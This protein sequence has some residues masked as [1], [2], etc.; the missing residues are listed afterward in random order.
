M[1]FYSVCFIQW[2]SKLLAPQSGAHRR[3]AVNRDFQS[4]PTHNLWA[5]KPVYVYRS[6]LLPKSVVSL[7]RPLARPTSVC[8]FAYFSLFVYL[9]LFAYFCPFHIFAYWLI[10]LVEILISHFS[11]LPQGKPHWP[12][13]GATF[14][15]SFPHRHGLPERCHRDTS[16]KR[17][18]QVLIWYL[19]KF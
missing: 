7:W 4:H 11:G 19:N 15:S 17:D 6:I 12:G 5:F 14:C 10:C 16:R 3:G 1:I 8:R 18:H 2:S 13:A 9:C